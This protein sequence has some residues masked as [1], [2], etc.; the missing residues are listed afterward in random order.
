MHLIHEAQ[1]HPGSDELERLYREHKNLV[2]RA[3]HRLTGNPEDAEDVLQ[4][5][6]MRLVKSHTRGSPLRA[7][8]RLDARDD[9]DPSTTPKSQSSTARYLC[10]AAINAALDVLRTR[11]RAASVALSEADGTRDPRGQPEMI[12]MRREVRDGLRQALTRLRPRAAEIFV[13][14]YFEGYSNHEIAD[15][16]G[17]SRATVAVI[18][19][20]SRRRLRQELGPFLGGTS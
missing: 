11:K 12:H 8:A 9:S 19:H 15:L 7:T 4:T 2:F 20:R 18:L 10:R 17:S 16:V 1:P 5:V 6:F 13:L 14:R 3:A